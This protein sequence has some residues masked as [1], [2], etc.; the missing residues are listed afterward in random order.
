[1]LSNNK[2]KS[3]IQYNPSWVNGLKNIN[4]LCGDGKNDMILSQRSY[5]NPVV[6]INK[7]V[8]VTIASSSVLVWY[9][10]DS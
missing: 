6:S 2:L 3:S 5:D 10:N 7:Y 1:M 4:R 8:N 9:W